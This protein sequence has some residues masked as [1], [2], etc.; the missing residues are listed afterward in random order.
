MSRMT[1]D[2]RRFRPPRGTT[3]LTLLLAPLLIGLG[4]WQVQRLEWKEA[5]LARIES[6]IEAAPHALPVEIGNPEAWEY[7]RVRLRGE[8]LHRRELHLARGRGWQ[9]ITPLRREHGPPVL[10]VR[11]FVPGRFKE[12]ASRP[13]S[14][15]EGAV[16]IEAVARLP[17]TPGTFTPDN[18][19]QENVWVWR[20]HEAMAEA[21]GLAR[22]V[23]LFFEAVEDAQGGWPQG[24]ITR[25]DIPNRHLGYAITWFS[26]AACIV[27]IYIVTGFRRGGERRCG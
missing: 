26:L 22:V 15:A 25:L 19:P 20:D 11:G 4:I 6:R 16:T 2:T 24:G 10:I 5:L 7:R 27:G 13:E 3:P 8:F 17:E 12:P 14:L 18:R 23:P 1:A 9:I 21:V